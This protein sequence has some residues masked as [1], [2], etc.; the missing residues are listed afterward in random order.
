MKQK[1]SLYINDSIKKIVSIILIVT[2]S[3]TS[4]PAPAY[5]GTTL[6]K[7]KSY[8]QRYVQEENKQLNNISK[9]PSLVDITAKYGRIIERYQGTDS[10]KTII[11]IQDRHIDETAQFNIAAIIEELTRKYNIYMLSL[12][13]ASKELDM[14]FYDKFADGGIKEKVVKFFVTQ[15]LFTG[16]EYYKITHKSQYLKTIGAEDKKLY[17]KHLASYKENQPDKESVLY[18]IKAVKNALDQL[19]DK[20]YSNDLKAV[21]DAASKYKD[22]AIS[23]ADY[24]SVIASPE[25]AKQSQYPNVSAFLSLA[26]EEKQINFTKAQNER[27]ALMKELSGVLKEEALKELLEKSIAFKLGKITDREFYGYLSVI[28]RKTDLSRAKSR[29]GLTKQSQDGLATGSAISNYKELSAYIDYL[30]ALVK[31]D[32]LK[33]FDEI[34]ALEEETAAALCKNDAQLKLYQY[35]KAAGLLLDL[36]DLKLTKDKLYYI[37]SRPE[38]FD[39]RNMQLFL[40]ENFVRYGINIPDK[41]LSGSIG[42]EAFAHSMNFY[43]IALKRDIALVENTLRNM[44]SNRKDKAILITGG[45]HTS[46]IT[47]ILKEKGIS[48]IVICPNL[49]DKDY[50]KLYSDRINGVIPDAAA[51]AGAFNSML[52]PALA[53]GDIAPAQTGQVESGFA[54]VFNTAGAA[55]ARSELLQPLSAN[56]GV[57]ADP[58]DP[59]L[60]KGDLLDPLDPGLLKGD[61]VDPLPKPPIDGGILADPLDHG[62]FIGDLVEPLPEPGPSIIVENDS[63]K[64]GLIKIKDIL[65]KVRHDPALTD[66]ERFAVWFALTQEGVLPVILGLRALGG[67]GY[68]FFDFGENYLSERI[69]SY[70]QDI[71]KTFNPRLNVR[72]YK[73]GDDG[74]SLDFINLDKARQVILDSDLFTEEEKQHIGQSD[75]ELINFILNGL[76]HRV[77]LLFGF[78]ETEVREFLAKTGPSPEGHA[79]NVIN[80]LTMYGQDQIGIAWKAIDPDSQDNLT[81]KAR[82]DAFF[83]LAGEILDTPEIIPEQPSRQDLIRHQLLNGLGITKTAPLPTSPGDDVALAA[84]KDRKPIHRDVHHAIEEGLPEDLRDFGDKPEAEQKRLLEKYRDKD[85]QVV[86]PITGLLYSTGLLGHIGLGQYYGEPVI[87]VDSAFNKQNR[88]AQRERIKA[89][90]R[91]EIEKWEQKRKELRLTHNQMREWIRRNSNSQGTGLAQQLAQQWHDDAPSIDDIYKIDNY[92]RLN[93]QLG[94]LIRTMNRLSLTISDNELAWLD[95]SNTITGRSLAAV[96][97]FSANVA[98]QFDGFARIR[99]GH[100]T[101]LLDLCE[102][103]NDDELAWLVGHEMGHGKI[104]AQFDWDAKEPVGADSKDGRPAYYRTYNK[105][106]SLFELLAKHDPSLLEIQ[107]FEEQMNKAIA[108]ARQVMPDLV[109][110]LERLSQ[111]EESHVDE[112]AVFMLQKGGFDPAAVV[113]AY[114]KVLRFKSVFK[115]RGT[116]IPRMGGLRYESHPDDSDRLSAMAEYIHKYNT[117]ATDDIYVGEADVVLAAGE[118]A[119]GEAAGENLGNAINLQ[120]LVACQDITFGPDGRYKVENGRV[121]MA[122]NIR[123]LKFS[124]TLTDAKGNQMQD[125]GIVVKDKAGVFYILVREDAEDRMKDSLE[126]ELRACLAIQNGVQTSYETRPTDIVGIEDGKLRLSVREAEMVPPISPDWVLSAT[127]IE[128]VMQNT[129]P[130]QGVIVAANAGPLRQSHI[131]S[132]AN[133]YIGKLSVQ[134]IGIKQ[135]QIEI[136]IILQRAR[137]LLHTKEALAL[138]DANI[139]ALVK[140]AYASFIGGR[141]ADEEIMQAL[142]DFFERKTNLAQAQTEGV[143]MTQAKP[144][145]P[146]SGIAKIFAET[147]TAAG[148]ISE[149]AILIM[150][151]PNA[152]FDENFPGQLAIILS[153]RIIDRARDEALLKEIAKRTTAK[154]PGKKGKFMVFAVNETERRQLI[155]MDVGFN[156]SNVSL[157]SDV[158]AVEEEDGLRDNIAGQIAQASLNLQGRRAQAVGIAVEAELAR[159]AHAQLAEKSTRGIPTKGIFISSQELPKLDVVETEA[160]NMVFFELIF[161]QLVMFFDNP[162][163]NESLPGSIL[164]ILP[165]I[166]SAQFTQRIDSMRHEVEAVASQA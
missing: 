7:T 162:I 88:A 143:S 128:R 120:G 27:D 125:D 54:T 29:E 76:G 153:T 114:E 51:L 56:G 5:A 157:I 127:S 61:L 48:Y 26:K 70:I 126:H 97:E 163:R 148:Q 136:E 47:N 81:A 60:P 69:V 158:L 117:E 9:D 131:R 52:I 36:Y 63:V 82:F 46:G 156:L 83:K 108:L 33:L 96:I 55:A 119:Q 38:Y 98:E 42:K 155:S 103:L 116:L 79:V 107:D 150:N 15:A 66:V 137:N 123:V 6:F 28:A 39:I 164:S 91:H 147:E 45:F 154:E 77:G 14:S 62:L 92:V 73:S 141:L 152:V 23:L 41:A 134:P 151:K 57:L 10:A 133:D 13:G 140:I 74:L 112:L 99:D 49:S 118:P 90:E 17:L 159:D 85:G 135:T 3:L 2:F 145:T 8:A 110:E 166:T 124:R 71:L 115:E 64:S 104:K 84:G 59:G 12:E 87:Y 165:A 22:K 21:D 11:H 19:K 142:T 122:E 111:Q 31:I 144:G 89:H 43:Q 101:V 139:S 50:E 105:I 138:F 149:Q 100:I 44:Y 16:S 34:E 32:Y 113:S 53:T 106:Y 78:P 130:G 30:N 86:I 132:A 146:A 20:I 4:A 160:R 40:K 65:L 37:N 121:N 129:K 72:L 80:P 25:G 93:F 67:A 109:E 18:L 161:A 75:S 24:L 58:L 95:A 68:I 35:A 1:H 94:R 102:V